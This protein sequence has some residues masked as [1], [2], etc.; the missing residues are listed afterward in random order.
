[1]QIVDAHRFD[2]H[3]GVFNNGVEIP[4]EVGVF[5]LDQELEGIKEVEQ[6]DPNEVLQSDWWK[7]TEKEH[8]EDLIA[9]A[10]HLERTGHRWKEYTKVWCYTFCIPINHDIL[11]DFATKNAEF[12]AI[13][14]RSESWGVADP[15]G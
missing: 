14:L 5:D 9:K 2:D 8:R 10:K 13:V 11:L 7:S 3:N 6:F 4:P 15:T 12:A 1:M